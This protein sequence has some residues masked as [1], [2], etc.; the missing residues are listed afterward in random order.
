MAVMTSLPSS[1]AVFASGSIGATLPH[2]AR[3]E[4]QR[5]L[6]LRARPPG[7]ARVLAAAECRCRRCPRLAVTGEPVGAQLGAQRDQRG[8]VVH[9][10]YWPRLGDADEAVRVQVIAEQEHRVGVGRL[11]QARATVVQQVA[12]VD[13]LE[14]ECVPLLGERREDRLSLGLTAKRLTPEP[15]LL[16]GLRDDRVPDGSRYSQ[17]ASSFVQ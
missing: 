9:R 10:L 15:A 7:Q 14:A 11:E 12:L 16:R 17:P 1:A 4:L 6:G 13:R 2:P 5:P 8:E 3:V